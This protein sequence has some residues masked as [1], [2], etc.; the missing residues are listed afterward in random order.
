MLVGMA[1][2]TIVAM[3]SEQKQRF[4]RP[5]SRDEIWCQL[6]E[7]GAGSDLASLST[8][9]ERDGDEVFNGQKVWTTS[10][11]WPTGRWCRAHEP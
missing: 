2:P 7:P 11:M 10:R 6:F 8:R 3:G 4:L 5:G 9:A 1:G